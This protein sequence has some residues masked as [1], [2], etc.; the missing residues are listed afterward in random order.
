ME[1]WWLQPVPRQLLFR[2]IFHGGTRA[3][4]ENYLTDR[5]Y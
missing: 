1:K 4:A 5:D 3:A 2:E